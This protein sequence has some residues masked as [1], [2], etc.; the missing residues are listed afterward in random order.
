MA[1][2]ASRNGDSVKH[3]LT[4]ESLEFLEE[5]DD[6]RGM[7]MSLT[8]NGGVAERGLLQITRSPGRT[9]SAPSNIARELGD[10]AGLR[11]ALSN[12]ADVVRLQE[13]YE[14]SRLLLLE[15]ARLFEEIGD[16]IGAAWTA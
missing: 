10:P 4:Q 13:E 12:L 1:S 2:F 9:S 15:A 14:L 8:L 7:L 16:G 11:E 5:L 3:R 6:P